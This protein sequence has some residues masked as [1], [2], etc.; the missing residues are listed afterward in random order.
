[1]S[2]LQKLYDSEINAKIEWFWDGGFEVSLGDPMNGWLDSLNTRDWSE[3]E[4]WLRA[5]AIERY[6]NSTFAKAERAAA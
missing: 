1:M 2:I 4:G 5:K 3:A 6:P